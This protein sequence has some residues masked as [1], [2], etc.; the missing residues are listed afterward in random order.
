MSEQQYEWIQVWG[1]SS[2]VAGSE[3]TPLANQIRMINEMLDKGY[4]PVREVQVEP[5]VVL[6]LLKRPQP[7]RRPGKPAAG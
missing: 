5:G 4:E 3:R 6:M 1:D 7:V 2:L